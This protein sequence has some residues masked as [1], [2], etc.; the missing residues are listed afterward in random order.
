MDRFFESLLYVGESFCVLG[1][2]MYHFGNGTR[3]LLQHLL[4]YLVLSV[5]LFLAIFQGEQKLNEYA[6]FVV[7]RRAEILNFL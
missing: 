7:Q 2:L 6:N 1:K 3:Q 5:D 4:H